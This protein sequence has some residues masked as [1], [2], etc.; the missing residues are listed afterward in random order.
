MSLSCSASVP[1]LSPP[2]P[3]LYS[4]DNYGR[5]LSTG[6]VVTEE[7]RNLGKQVWSG[8]ITLFIKLRS[9]KHYAFCP[10]KSRMSE[11]KQQGKMHALV[12]KGYTEFSLCKMHLA[13]QK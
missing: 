9:R 4:W 2:S 11:T 6:P 5:F 1:F 3:S 13:M 12:M 7:E 10:H 8:L